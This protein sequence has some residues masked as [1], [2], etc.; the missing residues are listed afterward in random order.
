MNGS[1]VMGDET[2]V[3]CFQSTGFRFTVDGSLPGI[4]HQTTNG[5]V[6]TSPVVVNAFASHLRSMSVVAN[7]SG[8]VNGAYAF[9]KG[10][11][12]SIRA[13][14]VDDEAVKARYNAAVALYVHAGYRVLALAGR[15]ISGEYLTPENAE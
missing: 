10:A 13:M 8:A 15:R 9:A 11:P 3:A 4:G 5:R 14:L 12:E 7:L 1:E 6:T 2:E